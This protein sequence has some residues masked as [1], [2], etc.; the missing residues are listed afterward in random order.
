MVLAEVGY[1]ISL[2]SVYDSRYPL[3]NDYLHR[4][5][6]LAGLYDYS[7]HDPTCWAGRAGELRAFDGDRAALA[8]YLEDYNRSL[9]APPEALASA[10]RVAEPGSLVVIGGQQPGVLLGP[11]Y[12]FWKAVA[13][14]QLARA[15]ETLL[16]AGTPVV[17]V[18]W[19]GAEDHDLAEIAPVNVLGPD[20]RVTRVVYDPAAGAAGGVAPPTRTSVGLLPASPSADGLLDRLERLLWKAEFTG[21]VMARLRSTAAA[22]ANLADWFGRLLLGVL[23]PRGLVVANAVD[24]R[25]RRLESP[26]FSRMVTDNAAVAALFA[27][28]QTRVRD[29][30]YEP[31]V[32]KDPESAN[33]YLYRGTER[34]QLYRVRPGPGTP[35]AGRTAGAAFRAGQGAEAELLTEA[36]LLD[37]AR[38]TPERLSTNVVLRPLA[39]DSVFPVLAYVGGPGE[40]SYFALYGGIYHHFGRRLPIIYPRPNVTLIEPAVRRHLGKCGLS[41]E[42]ALDLEVLE[43]A[44]EGCLKEAD[45]VG[46]DGLFDRI[47]G[48]FREG[49]AAVSGALA[50]LHPSLESLAVKNLGRVTAEVDWLRDKAWQQLRQNCRETVRRFETMEAYLRPLGDY[51]ERVFNLF[52]YLAKYGPGLAPDLAGLPLV[53]PDGTLQASHRFIWF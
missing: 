19:I 27:E 49:Y 15:A 6:A 53:P 20:G 26:M 44:K 13:V 40:T 47:T 12:T 38:S 37:I 4:Y 7:P 10:R 33:L 1:R 46:I 34:V 24:P 35:G 5:E 8:A 30:G 22:S 31:Q 29:L 51:Q 21:E 25:L 3:F 39:Q 11:L 9:G 45:P 14:V 18:F 43:R 50:R 32:D 42:Q 41:P 16:P 28:G 52:A 48:E 23:G 36:G 2:G 17:P